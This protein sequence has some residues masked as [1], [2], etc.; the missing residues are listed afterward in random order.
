METPQSAVPW[1]LYRIPRQTETDEKRMK[2]IES[3]TRG[4]QFS[5]SFWSYV[6]HVTATS[7]FADVCMFFLR[8]PCDPG[9]VQPSMSKVFCD[10]CPAGSYASGSGLVE[11]TRCEEG[12]G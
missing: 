9:S 12:P 3:S 7:G 11:C 1:Q 6:L 10:L 4:I 8:G 5:G 2:N